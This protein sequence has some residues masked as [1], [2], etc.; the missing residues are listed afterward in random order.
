L[1][2]RLA[3]EA[4]AA[5]GELRLTPWRAIVIVGETVDPALGKSLNRLGLALDEANPIRAVAACPGAPACVRG[6]TNTQRD[7]TRLAQIARDLASVGVGLHVSG[8]AKGCA[9][10]KSAPVALVGCDGR[11]DLVVDGFAGDEPVVR[12]VAIDRLA[13]LLALIVKAPPSRRP[14]VA[15]Q[16]MEGRA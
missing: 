4:D 6:S 1:L 14:E 9:H 15:R 7:G 16:F 12:G 3:E 5:R 13:D 11:Y 10:T 8:C 2:K